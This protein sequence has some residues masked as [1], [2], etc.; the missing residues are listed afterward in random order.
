M[1]IYYVAPVALDPAGGIQVMYRHVD[2]LN[3][4]GLSAFMLHP[5]PPFRCKWFEND[6][7]IRYLSDRPFVLP[8]REVVK[9]IQRGVTANFSKLPGSALRSL[10]D[11][12]GWRTKPTISLGDGDVLAIT[13]L[14][15]LGGFEL[16]PGVPRVV[17]NQGAY[18]TFRQWRADA[19]PYGH[20]EILGVM[21]V[22]ADSE[23][24]LNMAFGSR[25]FPIV[26]VHETVSPIFG[27]SGQPKEKI[28]AYMPRRNPDHAH[29]VL[30][31]LSLRGSLED[32]RIVEIDD[33][34]QE[35][36]AAILRKAA[37]FLSFGHLEGFGLPA[38]EAMSSACLVV[39][40]H[41]MGGREFFL[42]EFSVPINYGEIRAYVEAVEE[43][44]RQYERE[45]EAFRA[46]GLAA[47]EFVRKTYSP[48][49]EAR[50]VVGAW[51]A[52][53][54]LAEDRTGRAADASRG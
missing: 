21:T 31:L 13:E 11:K 12:S 22:S 27:V 2:I 4:A 24:Y 43:A 5:N 7:P 39:G 20:T 52:F 44:V 37:V 30:S 38:V 29:Q 54:A 8:L 28:I 33:V 47:A 42:P 34:T 18:L 25:A 32:W 36:V 17:F 1:T 3:R 53:L 6:T 46:R 41:G 48:E 49:R 50:D 10:T 40:Y 45:P 35:E 23:A 14:I 19:D 15:R 26:R 16:F 9:G 51:T